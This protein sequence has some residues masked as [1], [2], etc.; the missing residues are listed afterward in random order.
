MPT[1]RLRH[2]VTETPQVAPALDHAARLWPGEAMSFEEFLRIPSEDRAEY[3]D[4]CALVTPPP[5]FRHQQICPRLTRLLEDA[6]SGHGEVVAA[7]GW[8]RSAERRVRIPDVMVLDRAPDGPVVTETPRVV[9]EV[10]SSNRSDDLVRKSHEYLEAGVGQYWILDPRDETLDVF[11][12]DAGWSPTLRL[13]SADPVGRV[14][15]PGSGSV[16][17]DLTALLT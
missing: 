15:I 7:A 6:V 5:S 17:L 12:S 11:T 8:L 14:T 3:V 4:G 16:D 9:V 1:R 2:Q 13:T 10:F